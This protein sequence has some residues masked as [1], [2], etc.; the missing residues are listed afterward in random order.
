MAGF[1]DLLGKLTGRVAS[2]SMGFA[3]GTA[4]SPMLEP[5]AREFTIQA[6]ERLP[7]VPLSPE[8]AAN[9]VVQSHMSLEEAIAEARKSGLR[10][11]HMQLLVEINGAPPGPQEMLEL[12]NR[13][14]VTRD[15]VIQAIRESRVKPKY[16]EML[17]ELAKAIL[18]PAEAAEMVIRN[19][20]TPQEGERI[21]AMSGVAAE[22]FERMVR[23]TGQPPGLEMLVRGLRR[24]LIDEGRFREGVRQ[25][26]LRDEWTDLVIGLG[27]EILTPEQLVNAV[28]QGA[29]SESEAEHWRDRVGISKETFDVL[30]ETRG[31]P[32]GPEA[33]LRL[34]RRGKIT[35]S[36]LEQSLKESNLKNKWIDT[37]LESATLELPREVIERLYRHGAI[38]HDEAVSAVEKLGY[39][40]DDSELMIGAVK[41]EKTSTDKDLTKGE[42]VRLYSEGAIGRDDASGMLQ[43]LGYDDQE[44]DFLLTIS[45]FQ[46][47]SRFLNSAI[48]R[49]HNLYVNHRISVEAA[50]TAMDRLQ[51]PTEQREHLLDLWNEERDANV[52]VLTPAEI[53]NAAKNGFIPPDEAFTRL[54]QLGYSERDAAIL[55]NLS[56]VTY[57]IPP[58][59]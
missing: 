6:N 20:L 48:G 2:E 35:R 52:H 30:V 12:M 39:S 21:A 34:Y 13:G 23:I 5:I 24:N 11:E 8:E 1:R 55:L 4:A 29:M 53:R 42:I 22:D 58:L 14:K 31:N 16:T 19:V 10:D 43:D 32:P 18:S 54:V 49:V 40:S 26:H 15:Q 47:I 33:M 37:Y 28:V 25:S 57:D 45:D 56:K 36:E 41:A 38:K 51:V 46:R 17:L 7:N 27:E 44:A 9:A 3:I 50:T 59:Q